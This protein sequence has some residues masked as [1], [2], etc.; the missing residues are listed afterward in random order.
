MLV[1]KPVGIRYLGVPQLPPDRWFKTWTRQLAM[2][3]L[4]AYFALRALSGRDVRHDVRETVRL[5]SVRQSPTRPF[6]MSM[7]G[8]GIFW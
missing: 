6:L 3:F 4:T 1:C 7:M 5:T 8:Q 2:S